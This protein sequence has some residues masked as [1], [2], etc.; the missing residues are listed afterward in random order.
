M[1]KRRMIGKLLAVAGT[2]GVAALL[3]TAV[4]AGAVPTLGVATNGT[5]YT[6]GGCDNYMLF[7]AS[8][9]VS[10]SPEGFSFSSG[11]EIYLVVNLDGGSADD[12]FLLTDQ[13]NSGLTFTPDGGSAMNLDTQYTAQI[14]G[15]TLNYY[16]TDVG[17]STG[18]DLV[19][20]YSSPQ[21]GITFGDTGYTTNAVYLAGTI[22][23]DVNDGEYLFTFLDEGGVR[24]RGQIGDPNGV[25]DN[26]IDPFSPKTTS[27][28]GGG[29]GSVPEPGSLILMG[30]GLVGMA[31]LLRRRERQHD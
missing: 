14:D 18:W 11:D 19:S 8:S 15:Y 25:F 23:G 3:G 9:C 10:G 5:Y 29:G 22:S 20:S 30:S 2:V 1:G 7:W 31:F 6:S 28:P 16:G 4:P 24:V 27:A 12:L 26:G 21:N 13:T 17:A